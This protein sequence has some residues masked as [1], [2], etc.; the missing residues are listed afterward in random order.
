MLYLTDIHFDSRRHLNS[1]VVK[2]SVLTLGLYI[3]LVFHV[4]H[5]IISRVK[6]FISKNS[7]ESIVIPMDAAIILYH[8]NN[9][10]NPIFNYFTLRDFR[11]G[12]KEIVRY[13][14]PKL[15]PRSENHF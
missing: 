12:F 1:K 7:S 15:T 5:I 8:M 2:V 13:R 6:S 10:I 9:V 3:D 14:C 11:Q 4:P